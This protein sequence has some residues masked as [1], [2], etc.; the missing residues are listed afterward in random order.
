MEAECNLVAEGRKSKEDMM[1]PILHEM[2][3]IF[4][5]ATAESHKLETAVARHFTRIGLGNNYSVL[6]NHF[7]IC[8]VC[9]NSMSLKQMSNDRNGTNQHQRNNQRNQ[10]R[11]KLLSCEACSVALV[12]PAR[13]IH[14]PMRQGNDPTRC[15]IC[16]YQVISISEGDGYTG[17][18]YHIC[19][20]CFSDA[21]A[22][23]GGSSAGDF[24]CFSCTHPTCKLASGV[25]GGDVEVFP[26]P[27]CKQ[28]NKHG[29][30]SLKKNSKGFVLSC[31]NRAANGQRCAYVIW[32]PKEAS[33]ISILNDNIDEH[34]RVCHRCSDHTKTVRKIKFSWKPGSVPPYMS[35]EHIGCV[36]CD[37][38]FKS[39]IRIKLPQMNQVQRNNRTFQG[40]GRGRGRSNTYQRR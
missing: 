30:V 13:G 37:E 39:D 34:N 14:T 4:Q 27:F 9:N 33:S 36:L 32:L 2:K 24:R 8:G 29:K 6:T 35:R 12:L 31:S 28:L 5:Q 3:R 22:E 16:N 15:P 23:Y 20:K 25:Q 40:R 38:L 21:P 18:G 10:A 17:S 26:C 7:S 11:T 1:R 19:P